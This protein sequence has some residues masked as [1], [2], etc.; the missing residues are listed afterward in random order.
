MKKFVLLSC[1]IAV[2]FVSFVSAQDVVED[3]IESKWYVGVGLGYYDFEGDQVLEDSFFFAGRLGYDLN[4]WWSIEGML[5]LAPSMDENFVGEEYI[6]EHGVS[7][8]RQVSQAPAGEQGFDSTTA[9]GMIADGLFHF[10][11]WKRI[12]PFLALGGGVTFFGDDINGKKVDMTLRGG[13]GLMYHFNDEWAVRGDVRALIGGNNTEVN[14]LTDIGVVWYWDSHVSPVYVAEGGPLDSDGDGLTDVKE[15]EIGTDP[16]NPDSD[17]DGLSDGEE[18][19]TY[20]TDPLNKDTD[21]D[22]LTDGYD[23]VLKYKTDPLL[24]DTD[25]GGVADGHEVIEDGTDPLDGSDDLKLYELKIEFDYNKTNIKS[26]YDSD[27]AVIIKELTRNPGSEARI[28]GHADRTAKSNKKYNDDLSKRRA[29][30][31][32]K[33]IATKGG[34]DKSR[35]EAHGYGFSR[36]KE[37]NDPKRGNPVN[38]R[39]EVY[40]SGVHDSIIK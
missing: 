37:P 34:I 21:F 3:S 27:L 13:G 39:V 20:K 1:L 12:D 18:Y 32:L 31:V 33:Y 38:R 17:G 22:G 16:Y 15:N 23:E 26:R 9:F 4:E 11:R 40:I 36:P 35:L 8:E 14:L 5:T 6:D 24:R 10:T 25:N 29:E 19:L 2:V 7:G 28:E 30:A